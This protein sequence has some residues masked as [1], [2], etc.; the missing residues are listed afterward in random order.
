MKEIY[1]DL[2][3][4]YPKLKIISEKDDYATVNWTDIELKASKRAEVSVEESQI[5][6]SL[7]PNPASD[8]FQV[9]FCE[10]GEYMAELINHNGVVVLNKRMSGEKVEV[11]T[12]DLPRGFYVLKVSSIENKTMETRRLILK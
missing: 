9:D 10:H 11:L 2:L 6:E 8:N 3:A 5:I 4:N 12:W 7:F 1:P